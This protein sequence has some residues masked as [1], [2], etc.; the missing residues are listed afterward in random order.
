MT[1]N[2]TFA[3][4]RWVRIMCDYCA[5]GVWHKDGAG[6]C[7]DE[8]PVSQE[9]IDRILRWQESYETNDY[10]SPEPKFDWE[11]FSAEGLSIAKAIKAALPEWTVIYFDAAAS[12][13]AGLN[14][15]RHVY[16]YEVQP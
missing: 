6:G 7:A 12:M 11:A 3:E 9:L 4:E 13:R 2:T 15:P 14:V 1:D 10:N 8:L 16:E 5:D